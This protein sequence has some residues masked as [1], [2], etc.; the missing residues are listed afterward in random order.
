MKNTKVNVIR[1][2]KV[3]RFKF[4]CVLPTPLNLPSRGETRSNFWER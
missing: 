4:Y 3:H 1:P 2:K